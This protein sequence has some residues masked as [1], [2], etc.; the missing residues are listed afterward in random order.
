VPAAC[1]MRLLQQY[2]TVHVRVSTVQHDPGA[3][4]TGL[5]GNHICCFHIVCTVLLF[6][7]VNTWGLTAGSWRL[8]PAA[9]PATGRCPAGP[10]PTVRHADSRTSCIAGDLSNVSAVTLTES[11][12]APRL[13]HQQQTRALAEYPVRLG[14]RARLQQLLTDSWAVRDEGRAAAHLQQ[15]PPRVM[16]VRDLQ[17][18]VPRGGRRGV[19]VLGK[20]Q[21]NHYD[22]IQSHNQ[23]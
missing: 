7:V 2:Q 11:V 8:A 9:R 14:H 17:R 15:L 6:G 19:H 23:I 18:Q 20:L 3:P 5:H 22:G 13:P 10:P 1:A 4:D 16:R 12:S 21:V